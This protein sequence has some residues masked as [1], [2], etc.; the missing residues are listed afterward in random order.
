[1]S[2]KKK[3]NFKPSTTYKRHSKKNS[4]SSVKALAKLKWGKRLCFSPSSGP[5]GAMGTKLQYCTNIAMTT[6][7]GALQQ[8]VFRLN[9][10]HDPDYTGTGHQPLYYDQLTSYIY[11]Q[12]RVYGMRYYIQAIGEDNTA[13]NISVMPSLSPTSLTTIDASRENRDA[14]NAVLQLDRGPVVFKGYFDLA[15][16]FGTSR[17]RVLDDDGFAS[18]V[19]TQPNELA[20]LHIYAYPMDN[21]SA[22]TVRFACKFDY[23]CILN[24]VQQQETS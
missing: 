9:S 10:L 6:T 14:K 15:D 19:G 3:V 22:K 2:T 11:N 7:A 23:Y 5:P 8:Y 21:T 16:V 17:E 24:N 18:L 12:Y 1:M 4:K 13:M 20:Y